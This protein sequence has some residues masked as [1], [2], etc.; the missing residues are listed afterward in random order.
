MPVL[1]YQFQLQFPK[2]TPCLCVCVCVCVCVLHLTQLEEGLRSTPPDPNACRDYANYV[3]SVVMAIRA[4]G[5]FVA[6]FP[7]YAA[8]RKRKCVG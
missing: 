8:V 7:E 5:V 1:Q 6:A 2:P 3:T 4:A